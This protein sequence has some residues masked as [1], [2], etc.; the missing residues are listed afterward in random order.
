V[1]ATLLAVMGSLLLLSCLS[2]CTSDA[3]QGAPPAQ[4]GIGLISALEDRRVGDVV[5]LAAPE[6]VTPDLETKLG[7]V[8]D[9]FPEKTR[10]K[11]RLVGY[12]S[13]HLL[14]AKTDYVLSF[15]TSYPDKYLLTSMSLREK[16]G[17]S[18]SWTGI[19]VQPIRAPLEE[20]NRFSFAGRSQV[21][22][23][24]LAGM[25]VCLGVVVAAAIQ[26]GRHR[27]AL[28]HKWI[29]LAAILLGVGKLS[30]NWTTGQIMVQFINLQ[31]LGVG[32]WREGASGP[33]LLQVALPVGAVI[34]LVRKRLSKTESRTVA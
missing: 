31:L 10:G 28:R 21:H 30:L 18:L 33:W 17:A 26:W 6:T 19:N 32:V 14:G 16:D 12:R 15:E 3:D 27:K 7:K 8:A 29:W 22:Y 20:I 2:S 34:F 1:F 25:L 13:M 9:V 23:D 11:T 4:L 5:S 24:F